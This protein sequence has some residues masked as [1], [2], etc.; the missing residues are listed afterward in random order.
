MV[1]IMIVVVMLFYN[2][3]VWDHTSMNHPFNNVDQVLS[4]FGGPT[5][6]DSTQCLVSCSKTIN[7]IRM[8]ILYLTRQINTYT[9]K[10]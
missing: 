1:I 5:D 4:I 9:T 10:V 6:H 7:C 2:F 8:V 3:V